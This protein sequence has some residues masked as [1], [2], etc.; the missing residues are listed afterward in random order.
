MDLSQFKC[1]CKVMVV[2]VAEMLFAQ[3]H[4][5]TPEDAHCMA[6]AWMSALSDAAREKR[7]Q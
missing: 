7:K 6:D 2:T 1:T 4:G 5:V 3:R